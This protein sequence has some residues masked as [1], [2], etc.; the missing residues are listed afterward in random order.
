[1]SAKIIHGYKDSYPIGYD[2]AFISKSSKMMCLWGK[3]I[4]NTFS[5]LDNAIGSL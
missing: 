1:M 4:Q 3:M 2:K 5:D